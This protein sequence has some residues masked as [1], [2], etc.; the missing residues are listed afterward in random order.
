[1][2]PSIPPTIP[3]AAA[4]PS[5]LC[6]R[7][8][9]SEWASTGNGI[10]CSHTRS[11]AGQRHQVVPVLPEQEVRDALDTGDRVL[12]TSLEH[13][14]VAG[15]HQQR[16]AWREVIDG[17]LAGKLDPGAALAFELFQDEVISAGC[18][19]SGVRPPAPLGLW[20]ASAAVRA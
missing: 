2:S 18:G 13:A 5:A 9:E 8:G 16:L 19:S 7:Y 12:D 20:H 1:M 11:G 14:D 3:P 15:M 10:D 6:A 4:R 17:Q